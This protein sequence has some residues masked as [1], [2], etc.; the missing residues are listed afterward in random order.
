MLKCNPDDYRQDIASLNLSPEDEDE[1]LYTLWDMM[2]MFAE[3]GHGV[4]S[5]NTIFPPIFDKADQDNENML[6]QEFNATS[7]KASP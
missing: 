2:R 3:T 5:I 4:S 7:G 6:E 1:L